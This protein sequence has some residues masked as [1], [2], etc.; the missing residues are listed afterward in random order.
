[1]ALLLLAQFSVGIAAGIEHSK[2]PQLTSQAWGMADNKTIA[3]I[4]EKWLCCG[5]WNATDR[6]FPPSCPAP[7]ASHA[8]IPGCKDELFD[9][10]KSLVYSVGAAGIVVTLLEIATFVVTVVVV[11]R[12]RKI[13][14]KY[15]QVAQDDPVALLR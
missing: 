11:V 15:T 5:F 10:E 9:I 14:E 3:Y 1:M 7:T 12:I 6:P 13:Q 2:I 4:E 8:V